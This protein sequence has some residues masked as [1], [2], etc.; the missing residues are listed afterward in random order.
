VD[1]RQAFLAAIAAAPWDD[2][3]PR[4]VFADWLDEQGEHEEADRQRR[5]VASERWLR[6]YVD[7]A[8]AHATGWPAEDPVEY[9]KLVEAVRTGG[10]YPADMGVCNFSCD[11]DETVEF[12][13][14]ME[15][16]TDMRFSPEV[17]SDTPFYCTC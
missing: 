3:L 5:H 11:E 10:G 9:G 14:H 8:N 7:R 17:K 15:T 1:E 2:E 4:A 12:W 6:D 16:V 13:R